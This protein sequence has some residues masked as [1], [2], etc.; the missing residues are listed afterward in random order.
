MH[1]RL[2]TAIL[3]IFLTI[4]T[5]SAEGVFKAGFAKIDVTPQAATPMWGASSLAGWTT[6]GTARPK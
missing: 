5:A 1:R 3:T 6:M 4:N 2:N